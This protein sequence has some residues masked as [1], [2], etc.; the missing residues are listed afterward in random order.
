MFAVHLEASD[1]MVAEKDLVMIVI[2]S[3]PDNFNDLVITL[4]TLKEEKLS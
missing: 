2:S 4:E 3:L 1:D